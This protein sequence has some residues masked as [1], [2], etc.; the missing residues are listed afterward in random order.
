VLN[1]ILRTY[2]EI[3]L[4]KEVEALKN[5]RRILNDDQYNALA[6]ELRS[7][8]CYEKYDDF[9][10]SLRTLLTSGMK[11]NSAKMDFEDPT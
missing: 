11:I 5:R 8:C 2:C 4:S 1:E 9:N 10:T 6:E 7:N 3:G